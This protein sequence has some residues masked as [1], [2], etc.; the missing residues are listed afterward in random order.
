M[1]FVV[2]ASGFIGF[3]LV[4]FAGLSAE[5]AFDLVLRDAAFGCLAAGW[6]GRWFWR[7]LQDAAV[8]TAAQRR[9]A[10]EADAAKEAAKADPSPVPPAPTPR[11]GSTPPLSATAAAG[12]GSRA[13]LPVP[14]R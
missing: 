4:T 12:S 9:A 2:L 8:A 5:R 1:R 14:A 13:A 3:A 6:L 7:V 11:A 10:A